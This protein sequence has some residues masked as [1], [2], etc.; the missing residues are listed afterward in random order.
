MK[1]PVPVDGLDQP[2]R[3][4]AWIAIGLSVTL[5]VLDGT[6]ANVA[7]PTIAEHFDASPSFAI[8]IVNGYQ[9]SIVVSL[10]PMAALGEI[11][12]Y[13]RVYLGGIAV[14]TLASLLCVFSNSLEMLTTARIIQG[15]GAAGLMSI[16]VALLRYIVPRAKFGAAVGINS[17]LGAAA[18]TLG[19]TLAGLILSVA[20]WPWLFA[21]NLP[22]G[23]AAVA[24]GIFNLPGSDRARR[25]FD[26]ATAGLSTIAFGLV[27]IVIDSIGHDVAWP[28]VVAE[29][30]FCLSA[31]WLLIRRE[32][33]IREPMLPVDLLRIPAF[34]LSFGTS[35]SSFVGQMLAFVSL[36]FIFQSNYGF[37]PAEVGLAIMPWPLATAIAA[38][39]S[40]R[41][42]DRFS[43]ALLGT[44]GLVVFCV[45]LILLAVLLTDA[46]IPDIAWRMALCG[47]GFGFFQ[48]P[49][50]RILVS[51]APKR[52]SG[53]ASGML[54]MA[55]LTGQAIGAAL[56]ALILGWF[57]LTGAG[58]AL[59]VGASFAALAAVISV[60]RIRM[61][62]QPDGA[63]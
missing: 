2:Q 5:A 10:L 60:A 23:V 20:S 22:L 9:L 27:I 56:V 41:F 38:P 34:A 54:A 32:L 28:L 14:F 35:I 49:N 63:T 31:F 53:A 4:F 15:F 29:A 57:G 18:A 58:M 7:L 16:N 42:S 8:W 61:F 50:N 59:Y 24:T 45:G 13:R 51:S 1:V 25:R 55:R 48:S 17:F 12:G 21:I 3:L 47:A 46:S 44:G 39:I 33:G 40:G 52:R 62:D 36:P 19:P 6:I 37:S 30:A 43:P 11:Y 26:W